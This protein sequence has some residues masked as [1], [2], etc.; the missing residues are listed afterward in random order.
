[1]QNDVNSIVNW[2]QVSLL[3]AGNE[4]SIRKSGCPKKYNEAIQQLHKVLTLWHEEYVLGNVLE[5][6][7]S[8]DQI[9]ERI[10]NDELW[11]RL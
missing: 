3:L 10:S 8:K 11:K 7:F 4:G 2:R 9:V 1:M 6:L 5:P